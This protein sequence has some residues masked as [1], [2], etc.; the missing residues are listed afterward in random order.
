MAR[1]KLVVGNWKMNLN[2]AGARELA[3]ALAQT[4]RPLLS[5][6]EPRVQAAACPAFVHLSTVAEVLAG[7]A[8]AW[9]AQNV[10][11]QAD[12]AFTGEIS[13]SM[14]ADLG[15]R[16]V[17]L[18]HSERRLVLGEPDGEINRKLQ[19]VLAAGLEPIVCVGETLEQR[20][21]GETWQVIQTQ[22]EG[23]LA[24]LTLDQAARL[25]LAY[26]P[27][28]AIGTGKNATPAQAQEVHADLRKWLSSRY[29]QGLAETVRILYGGSVKPDNARELM[30]QADIDGALVGGA[31]LKADSFAAI[32]AAAGA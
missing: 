18:G 24:G 31:S 19:A 23:S 22:L 1:N 2:R 11:H 8:V 29:N 16:F 13:T 3:A 26:E 15:C 9:G 7:T 21:K 5:S 12:G 6:S 27:V 25:V 4:L 10:Y 28:W 30:A 32:V 17:I 20:E 14:L